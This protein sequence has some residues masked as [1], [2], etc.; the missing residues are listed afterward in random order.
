MS[1]AAPPTALPATRPPG[2]SAAAGRPTEGARAAETAAR[3]VGL[4]PPSTASTPHERLVALGVAEP[5]AP[6]LIE[7]HG[8]AR[9][10]DALDAVDTLGD[11]AVRSRAGWVVSAIRQG[12]ELEGLLAERR[13]LEAR[14]GRWERERADRDRAAARWRAHESAAGAWRAAVS[15]ALDDRQL[16]TA[17]ERATSPVAGLGRRSIPIVRAQLLAWAVAAHRGAPERPLAEALADD[18]AGRDRT[19]TAPS[20]D[21]PLPPAPVGS[22]EPVDDLTDRLTVLLARRPDL[23]HPGAPTHERADGA[24]GRALGGGSAMAAD[25]G[26]KASGEHGGEP[27][28][29][30]HEACEFTN[31]VEYTLTLTFVVA[32]G[33]RWRTAHG[34]ARTVAERLANTAARVKGVVDVRAV[35][36]ASRDGELLAPERVCFEAANSGHGTN[37]EPGKLDRYLDPDRERALVSLA[38][39]HAAARVWQQADRDRR[40]AIGCVNPSQL[41]AGLGR[42]CGCAYCRPDEHLDGRQQPSSLA[43]ASGGERCLCGRRLD[44]PG[45]GCGSHRGQQLLVLDGDP[46]ELVHL[47]VVVAGSRL[48]D[49]G[50]PPGPGGP[51]LPPPGR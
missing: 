17:V 3:P 32:G 28:V 13:Q 7:Q 41:V 42:A 47:A 51:A 22:G 31:A 10:V 18:L 27:P 35:A 16:A 4:P 44:V 29:S 40:G 50:R 23:S 8:Q 45:P 46:S 25:P 21:G 37:A 20:V 12:W 19:G 43:D 9:V 6:S 36:S 24:S 1:E 14:Y 5:T 11:R 38:E 49:R 2:T 39:S 15:A 26:Q 33:A 34:R 48:P 30:P